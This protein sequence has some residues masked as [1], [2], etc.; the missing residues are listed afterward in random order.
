MEYFGVDLV[1]LI[2]MVGLIGLFLIVFAE[3]GLFL[4]FFFPGDSLLFVAGL[5]AAQGFFSPEALIATIAAAAITGNMAGYWFGEKVGPKLFDRED[6]LLFRKQHVYRAQ[7]FYEE[8]G[9]KTIALARFIPI[10]R[11]FAP[12]VAGVA[13][14][15]YRTFLA[16]NIIGGLVWTVGLVLGGY[17]FGNLISDVDR[18]LLPVILAIIVVSFLPAVWHVMKERRGEKTPKSGGQ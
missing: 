16:Y 11:T 8:H 5:L 13:K 9:A 2:K 4:G 14:M 17:L 15:Q 6:S 18:Y 10:V 7:A 3:T 12:I 1:A